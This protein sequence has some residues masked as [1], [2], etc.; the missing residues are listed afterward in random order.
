MPY[1]SD[2]ETPLHLVSSSLPQRHQAPQDIE[3][4]TAFLQQG[5]I[6]VVTSNHRKALFIEL[7]WWFYTVLY[8]YQH[9]KEALDFMNI[10][11][12]RGERLTAPTLPESHYKHWVELHGLE[13]VDRFLL[14]TAFVA[15]MGN[16]IFQPLVEMRST[17][18]ITLLGGHHDPEKGFTPS[19]QTVLYLLC[20]PDINN[21]M[22]YQNYF[23]KQGKR[24]H[25]WG[26]KF[27]EDARE[28]AG[29][30]WRATLLTF[31]KAIW[32][33]L[34]G[35]AMPQPEE[36]QNL[37]ITLRQSQH[38]MDTIVLTERVRTQLQPVIKFAQKGQSF[39]KDKQLSGGFRRGFVVLLYGE[40]GTGKTLIAS[41]IG[42][43]VGLKT[44]QLEV[45]QVISK[46][47]GETSQNMEKVFDELERAI[48][49]LEGQPSIL[50][51]DEADAVMGKRSETNDSKDRYA[52]L[53]TSFLLQRLEKFPGLVILATNFPQNLDEAFKRR[54]QT[55]IL[56]PKPEKEE[57]VQLWQNYLPAAFHYPEV[58]TTAGLSVDFARL[59]GEKFNLTGAQINNI[60]KQAT[61]MAYSE[62]ETVLDFER[63]LEPA[64]I[65]ELMK[66]DRVYKRPEGIVLEP[67]EVQ[68][69]L[70]EKVLSKGWQ[71]EPAQLPA[72]LAKAVILPEEA[73][74]EL[75]Q[76]AKRK[77]HRRMAKVK[78]ADS[79]ATDIITDKTVPK[80]T[81]KVIRYAE[82]LQPLLAQWCSEQHL[83][84]ESL[85]WTTIQLVIKGNL[86][87]E[88]ASSDTT[89]QSANEQTA[90]QPTKEKTTPKR[91]PKKLKVLEVNVALQAWKRAL[92]EGFSFEFESTAQKLADFYELN[93]Y[94][95]EEI[96]QIAVIKAQKEETVQLVYSKHLQP[97]LKEFEMAS[98]RESIYRPK[99][100]KQVA[101]AEQ[102]KKRKRLPL[103]YSPT[104]SN[105]QYWYHYLPDHCRFGTARMGAILNEHFKVN[106]LEIEWIVGRAVELAAEEGKTEISFSGHLK[107]AI[108]E[109]ENKLGVTVSRS[110]KT[111][112]KRPDLKAKK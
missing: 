19:F 8:R 11:S 27:K 77:A 94:E 101:R 105:S 88:E 15:H 29:N 59:L 81:S 25:N 83:Q 60:L 55:Q 74:K 64:I 16:N 45:A 38:T 95:I 79:K 28:A 99:V 87:S 7:S 50:F 46:Y 51:I 85:D 84:A 100:Q 31:D 67:K 92:P 12:E 18:L 33:Y 110:T 14:A 63:F 91:D 23:Y 80:T 4:F 13:A 90:E 34:E 71:Y 17:W 36:N 22:N 48:D 56:V 66:V 20:G 32:H 82:D 6:S 39:F 73:L 44:Y 5:D 40:P 54:I 35:E 106:E 98:Q 109:L 43:H 26:I 65:A 108:A 68:Q 103:K 86:P 41:T 2:S 49:W 37:P 10:T 62:E 57:R 102:K 111:D 52:N 30:D 21:Q 58:E 78:K 69:R 61:L 75:Y 97:A 76:K 112:N 53:D 24:L 42:K 72:I 1:Q 70:W 93:T 9:P 104:G 96:I 89:E 3:Q 47:I 107:K